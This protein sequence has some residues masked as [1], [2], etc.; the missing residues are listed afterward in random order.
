MFFRHWSRLL[1]EGVVV[2]PIELPGRG[3]RLREPAFNSITA[4]LEAMT[5]V[6]LNCLDRPFAFFG[7]SMGAT[8]G[9]EVTRLLRRENHAQPLHLFV[10]GRRAPQIP[11]LN[12][13]TYDLADPDFLKELHRL[14]GTPKEVLENSEVMALMLPLLRADFRLVQTYS[15]SA[16]PPL[17]CPI[18]AFGGLQDSEVD[19]VDLEAWREQTTSSFSL[20]MFPGDHFFVKASQ[21]Q[22][23]QVLSRE[24]HQL[25]RTIS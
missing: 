12:P 10:S 18:S 16:A 2:C 3:S 20:Q 24:L 13:H 21:P 19:R 14:N 4:L 7:H 9:F 11:D 17:E 5:P 25:L 6:L 23:L 22:L 1:P 15:Y 8:I